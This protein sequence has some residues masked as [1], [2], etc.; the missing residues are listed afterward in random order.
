MIVSTDI[1][2]QGRLVHVCCSAAAPPVFSGDKGKNPQKGRRKFGKLCF[3]PDF[4]NLENFVSET[5]K[6]LKNKIPQNTLE[7]TKNPPKLAKNWAKDKIPQND[8]KFRF[9]H[10][11]RQKI[12]QTCGIVAKIRILWTVPRVWEH[13][14]ACPFCQVYKF[15]CKYS[16][17]CPQNQMLSR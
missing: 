2:S 16:F 17:L 11:I 12:P 4:L 15:Y 13:C 3:A 14:T 5:L 10:Q 8:P 7:F 9:F 6:I 1:T